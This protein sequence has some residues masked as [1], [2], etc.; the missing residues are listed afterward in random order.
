[1][2]LLELKNFKAIYNNRDNEDLKELAQDI[3]NF[4]NDFVNQNNGHIGSNLGVVELTLSILSY[5]DLDDSIVLFDTG[6]QSHIYKL[7]VHGIEKFKTI[8]EY[9][10]LSNFQEISESEYDWISTGHSSTSI[11][12]QFGYA[13]ANNKKNIISIIGDA[14]F[15]GS[16]THPGLINLQ[17]IDKKTITILNDNNQAIGKNALAIKDIKKYV[18]SIGIKYIKCENGHDFEELFNSFDQANNS[19]EHVFI[20]CITKKAHGYDGKNELF[21]NHSI[22]PI[23]NNSYSK[24]IAQEI[25]N[26][27]TNNDYLICPAMISSSNF[28]NLQNKF[29]KNVIDVGINE[30]FS[31]LTA[32]A[33]ANSNKKTFISIYS[34]FFQRIFDQLVHDVFRNNLPM[35][36]LIDRG[37]LSFSGGVSHHGI[38]DISL[39]NNFE[40]SIICQPYSVNDVKVL[41]KQAYLN[42]HKQFF[43]RYEN[44]AAI[45]DKSQEK[46]KIGQWQELIFD[47]NNTLTLIAYGNILEEFYNIIREK[48]LNINLINARYINPIDEEMIKKHRNNIIFVYEQVINKNNLFSNM[49]FKF[50]N[51]NLHSFSFESR[52]IKHGNKEFLLE[53]FNMN[54]ESIIKRIFEVPKKCKL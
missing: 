19:N 15:Y 33:I 25:E 46:F 49:K 51:L 7:L 43:L 44:L 6:H 48:K 45:E 40:N 26:N 38:Y 13:I 12:Y 52:N 23:N 21:E 16:Y 3:R 50:D 4:L 8:K 30:E 18:E 5:F 39:I 36:F 53:E 14:A 37:G 10:G 11:A 54:V 29:K 31:I 22:E 35:T 24:L 9:N 20:H 28:L 17:N 42:T 27:F 1:M 32:S 41:A 47:E 2:K 34:T